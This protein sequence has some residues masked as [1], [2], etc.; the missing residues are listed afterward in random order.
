MI[1]DETLDTF[2]VGVI[3]TVMLHVAPVAAWLIVSALIIYG[4]LSFLFALGDAMQVI[5][6]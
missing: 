2:W 4:V 3:S 6:E 1:T 5:D